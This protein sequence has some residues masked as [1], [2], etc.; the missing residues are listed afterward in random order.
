[1]TEALPV[2]DIDLAGIDTAERDG[3]GQGVCVGPPVAGA[4]VRIAALGFDAGVEVPAAMAAGSTGE[5]LVR[6]PWV[7]DGYLARWMTERMARPETDGTA[8][9]TSATSIRRDVSGSRDDR[10]T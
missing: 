7:S 1:M 5:I 2:A 8:P 6:A 9:A 4:E 3:D 10:S